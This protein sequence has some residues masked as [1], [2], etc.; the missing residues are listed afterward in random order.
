MTYYI[1]PNSQQMYYQAHAQNQQSVT[2]TA[3]TPE[4]RV[5]AVPQNYPA[6][7]PAP[8]P[9]T[10]LGFD[11]SSATFWKGAVIGAGVTLLVTSETVQKA[12]VKTVSKGMAAA[13][14][15]VEELKEKFEDAR[16]EV[17]AEAAGKK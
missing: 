10:F 6:Q 5:Y 12:V 2:D 15:G 17:E 8:A 3:A 11:I 4:S 14:A 7:P 1:D 9:S 13:S 16:A